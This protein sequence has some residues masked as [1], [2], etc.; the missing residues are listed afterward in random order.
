[1][2]DDADRRSPQAATPPSSPTRKQT[3][4]PTPDAAP[5]SPPTRVQCAGLRIPGRP[6][7]VTAPGLRI[8]GRPG[9][10][11]RQDSVFTASQSYRDFQI[12]ALYMAPEQIVHQNLKATPWWTLGLILYQVFTGRPLY[13]LGDD[14]LITDEA[15]TR[16]LILNNEVDLSAVTDVRQNLLLQGLLTKDPDDRWTAPEVRRWLKGED[17]PV[18]R[19]PGPVGQPSAAAPAMPTVPSPSAGSPT[20]RTRTSRRRWPGTRRRP[21]TGCRGTAAR[22]SRPGCATT[23]RTPRTTTASCWPSG[24]AGTGPCAP[25]SR[26]S[27]SSPCSRRPRRRRTG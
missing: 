12:T 7:S 18:V 16:G 8:P 25:R 4:D 1:M 10:L 6:G 5:P 2:A 3:P 15:W 21:P 23:S 26:R 19:P 20:T 22:A 11:P 17:P 9:P 27:P 14:A 24:A 13:V